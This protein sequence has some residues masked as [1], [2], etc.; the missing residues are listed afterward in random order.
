MD[1]AS[2]LE[3]ELCFYTKYGYI[4]G[5]DFCCLVL[6][7]AGAKPYSGFTAMFFYPTTIIRKSPNSHVSFSFGPVLVLCSNSI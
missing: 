1:R 4:V 7:I 6:V 2:L 3:G 5:T